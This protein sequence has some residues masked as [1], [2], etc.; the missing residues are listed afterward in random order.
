MS[1]MQDTRPPAAHAATGSRLDAL[2]TRLVADGLDGFIVP[3]ADEHG[4]EYVGDYAQR[5]A[6]L[7]GFQGS[8]GTAVVLAHQAAIFVDGRYTLQVRAQVDTTLFDPQPVP[9][10]GIIAW[11]LANAPSGARIGFDPWLHAIDELARWHAEARGRIEFVP[12]AAN[13]V[14]AIWTDRPAPPSAP[15]RVHPRAAAGVDSADKRASMA[16]GLASEGC[17]AVLVTALDSVAW[18]LNIRGGDV[19]HTPVAR[20]FALVRRDATCDLFIADGTIDAAVSAHLGNSI[21]AHP[22][23]ALT[24]VFPDF[25]GQAMAIDPAR[26]VVAIGEALSSA[27]VRIVA[28]RDPALLPKAIKNDA[29][30]AG[31][32]AAHLRD[33]VAICRFLAWLDA[34]APGTVDELTVA[35]R[36]AAFRALHPSWRDASFDTIA[37]AGPNGAI[38]HYRADI[39]TNRVAREGDLFLI[40]SGA[41]YDDGT[42]DIT[43]TVPIGTPDGEQIRRFTQVL[44]GHIALSRAVFPDGTRGGQIDALAR[45]PLWAAGCDY[46]HGTGHGVGHAL[47]VHEGPARIAKP[48]GGQAGTDEP[49]RAG[50]ILSNEP[51]YYRPGA[52]GIRIENLVLIVPVT[53]DGGDQPMLAF[54][55]LTLAPIDR[56]LI[57]PALLSVDEIAWI[58]A[59]HARVATEVGPLLDGADA[60][61]LARATTQLVSAK[62]AAS[63]GAV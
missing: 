12:V 15:L 50:M 26:T 11:A 34:Q 31:M 55:P 33:G 3:I 58:D 7:T 62:L 48:G 8:A 56:R 22:Y 2:R 61:W 44:R 24:K 20:A 36:L 37:G 29:E 38:M 39:E 42:T 6:W 25:A 51:G 43:R 53:I 46:A 4:S 23:D 40:D 19:A 1:T 30:I 60:E 28:M 59:Y 14:D 35:E 52:W 49:L 45:A 9:G 21:R 54:E 5:L 27:G 41:Q 13:P 57:D 16:D 47:A 63:P 17:E 10:P 32:R 18:T